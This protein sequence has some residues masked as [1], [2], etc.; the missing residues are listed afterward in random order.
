MRA[1]ERAQSCRAGALLDVAVQAG[2]S[3]DGARGGCALVAG[4]RHR[5]LCAT[6]L[7]PGRP[8]CERRRAADWPLRRVSAPRNRARLAT[9]RIHATVAAADWPLRRVSTPRNRA[10]LATRRIHACP[11]APAATSAT[12]RAP[13]NTPPGRLPHPRRPKCAG[14]LDTVAERPTRPAPPEP[15]YGRRATYST[16]TTRPR[17]G[18]RASHSTGTANPAQPQCGGLSAFRRASFSVP[19]PRGSSGWGVGSLPGGGSVVTRRRFG[20]GFCSSDT[21]CGWMIVIGSVAGLESTPRVSITRRATESG[22]LNSSKAC[23][24]R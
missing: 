19:V 12:H 6:A 7:R 13:T 8:R 23:T 24:R 21:Y 20:R 2:A 17:Y 16:G 3:T 15:R 9:R 14:G 18:R 22:S 5:T 11:A 4:Y 10:R 1:F